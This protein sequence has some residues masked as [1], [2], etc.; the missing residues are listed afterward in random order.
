MTAETWSLSRPWLRDRGHP[1][2]DL[3]QSPHCNGDALSG[4]GLREDEV[5]NL[6]GL[7]AVWSFW[8]LLQPSVRW[9]NS[10]LQDATNPH[11][12]HPHSS[13]GGEK[14]LLGEVGKATYGDP[15]AFAS[16]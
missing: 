5:Q 9:G 12:E 3:S 1:H 2:A 16:P 7:G 15:H 8:W 14:F 11:I 10:L 4:M 6:H 13:T